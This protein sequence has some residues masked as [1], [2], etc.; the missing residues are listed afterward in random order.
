MIL[1]VFSLVDFTVGLAAASWRSKLYPLNWQPGF[2][3]KKKRFLQDYSYAGYK[4]GERELPSLNNT[5]IYDLVKDF[6]ADN[7]GVADASIAC[8]KAIDAAGRNGG[9]I[10]FLPQ[11]L[12]RFDHHILVSRSNIII[13]GEGPK[14]T[15]IYFPSSLSNS[16]NIVFKGHEQ[17]QQNLLLAKDAGLF[18]KVLTLESIKGIGVG[19]DITVGAIISK[20][21]CQEHGMS[22]YWTAARNKWRPFFRRTVVDINPRTKEVVLDVPIRYPLKKRDKASV[23]VVTGLLEECGLRFLAVA[24]ACIWEDAWQIQRNHIILFDQVKD[25]WIYNVHS[26]EPNVSKP[27]GYHLLSSGI[28]VKGSKRMSIEMCSMQMAQNRGPGGNGYLFEISQSSEILVKDCVASHGQRNFIQSWDFNT[29]GCVFLRVHSSEGKKYIGRWD[30]LGV[31]AYSG[32][33][34]SLSVANLVDSSVIDDGWTIVNNLNENKGAGHSGTQNVFWNIRGKG[35]VHSAQ[36]GWGYIIGTGKAVR[37]TTS[38][39]LIIKGNTKPIDFVEGQGEAASLRPVSLYEDQLR[40]RLRF[41]NQRL[42][43]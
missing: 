8:Q 41:K 42:W 25:C 39:G 14:K 9:G 21:F 16:S 17:I 26:F 7:T 34:H 29:N 30:P 10:I 31:T 28:M 12:Y 32:F 13:T 11:G 4:N 3:D 40:R 33:N 18:S 20:A 22:D 38:D 43:E 6:K 19:M 35:T 15:K 5:I 27:K 23:Q 24:N 36:F 37:I 1:A 2:Q